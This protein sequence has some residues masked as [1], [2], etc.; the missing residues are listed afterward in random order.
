MAT[1]KET[2]PSSPTRRAKA[3]EE[4]AAQ[5]VAISTSA[6]AEPSGQAER[7]GSRMCR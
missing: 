7:Q 3:G 1:T 2:S 4:V 6:A 5:P